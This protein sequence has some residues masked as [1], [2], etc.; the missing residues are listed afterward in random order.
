MSR[1]GSH[2]SVDRKSGISPFS[3]SGDCRGWKRASRVLYAL[4]LAMLIIPDR[5]L[6]ANRMGG[7]GW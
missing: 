3:N 1:L 7:D 2:Q 6:T 4:P 5:G